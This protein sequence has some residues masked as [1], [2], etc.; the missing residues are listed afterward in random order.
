[1]KIKINEKLPDCE[2]FQLINEEPV[3]LKFQFIFKQ[4]NYF[5][6]NAGSVY[7]SLFCKTLPSFIN[8]QKNFMKKELTRFFALQQMIHL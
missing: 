6:R 3:K 1:M 2:V 4:K 8:F 5:I 7:F